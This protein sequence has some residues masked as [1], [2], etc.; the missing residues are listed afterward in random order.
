MLVSKLLETKDFQAYECFRVNDMS[1]ANFG[2]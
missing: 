2:R 1:M